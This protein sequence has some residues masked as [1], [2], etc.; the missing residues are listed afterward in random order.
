MVALLPVLLSGVVSLGPLPPPEP[1]DTKVPYSTTLHDRVQRVRALDGR[2]RALLDEGVRRSS[3]FARLLD[4]VAATDIIVYIQPVNRLAAS[5]TGQ[6]VLLPG[7]QTQR[8]L[9]IQ[10]LD[11]LS[12]DE[13]I[14]LIGHELRHVLEVAA[15]PDVRDQAALSELYKRI[16][17]AGGRVHS[18]D[19]HDAQSTGRQVR[20]E[21]LG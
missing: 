6:L 5:I 4:A 11:R 7:T 16:G 2:V 8:Y 17:R 13:T 15:A 3:T 14:A 9:R 12:P 18:F 1:I 20:M 21:L 10:I 19:T